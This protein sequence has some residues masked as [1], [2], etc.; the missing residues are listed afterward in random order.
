MLSHLKCMGRGVALVKA[1]LWSILSPTGRNNHSPPCFGKSRCPT[2]PWVCLAGSAPRPGSA[3]GR[4]GCAPQRD[5]QDGRAPSQPTLRPLPVRGGIT[6]QPSSVI[7]DSP[8]GV[9]SE[10]P[11]PSRTTW[12]S[13]WVGAAGPRSWAAPSKGLLMTTYIYYPGWERRG[14]GRGRS[15]PLF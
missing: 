8:G 4:R 1:S 13:P 11:S 5:V 12:G 3:P 2:W 6:V 9:W 14:K 10:S 15:L 7:R